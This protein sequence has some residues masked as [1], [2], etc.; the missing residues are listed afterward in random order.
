MRYRVHAANNIA[1]TTDASSGV[2]L[3]ALYAWICYTAYSSAV[4]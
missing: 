3:L 4:S 1:T 2:L